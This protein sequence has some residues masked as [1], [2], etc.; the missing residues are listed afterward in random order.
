ML[1]DQEFP[2]SFPYQLQNKRLIGQLFTDEIVRAVMMPLPLTRSW[3]I[4]I[5]AQ[6]VIE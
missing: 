4:W 1:N 2:R 3:R 6:A 5:K